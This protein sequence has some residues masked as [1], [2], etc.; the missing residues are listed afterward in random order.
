MGLLW[1]INRD[2]G[3]WQAVPLEGSRVVLPH[4][5]DSPT[6]PID[7]H[8]TGATPSSVLRHYSSSSTGEGWVLL[9]APRENIY[10]N[11]HLLRTGIQVLQ[12][13]DEIR[14]QGLREIYF[15]AEQLT[16]IVE[17]PGADARFYCPRC[18]KE[19]QPGTWAVRCP[20]PACGVWHHQ[21]PERQCWLYSDT[22]AL[23]SQ[24]T[25]LGQ[26]FR[27]HPEEE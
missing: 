5:P 12:D 1:F 2:V 9:A 13:R 25:A 26:G 14:Y 19:I 10:I 11:G 22:C 8:A 4:W 3:T 16:A 27:W 24:T 21:M 17:F 18:Q 15:S 7:A 23:C 20:N 6:G